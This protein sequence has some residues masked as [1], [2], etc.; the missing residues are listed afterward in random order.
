MK[1]LFLILTV[2]WGSNSISQ[3]GL[4][5]YGHKQS[6]GMGG[7]IGIDYNAALQFNTTCSLYIFAQDALE[8]GSVN[9]TETIRKN[10]NKVFVKQKFSLP[11]GFQYYTDRKTQ[12]LMSRDLGLVYVKEQ[13]PEIHWKISD[14]TKTI[15]NFNC[16]KATAAFRGRAYTAWFTTEIPLPYGPW[17]LQGLPGLILEAYD[18]NKE[19]YFYFKSIKYPL[20]TKTSIQAP[21]PKT[22]QKD[23]ISFAEYKQGLIEAHN[24]AIENG[25]MFMEDF[26]A[27]ENA[28]EKTMADSYIEVFDEN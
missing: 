7:P 25:R 1:H 21:D 20:D 18:T 26:D 6:M 19:V 12:T 17:K 16:I 23:W 2:L 22:E 13:I 8:G 15:G 11:E 14:D 5:T 4:V 3:N 27:E 24:R 28:E 10:K 9:K